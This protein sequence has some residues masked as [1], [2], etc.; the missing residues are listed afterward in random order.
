MTLNQIFSI[1]IIG[2]IY[3]YSMPKSARLWILLGVSLLGA[4]WLQPNLSIRWLDYSLPTIS[5]LIVLAFWLLGRVDSTLDRQA[6]LTLVVVAVLILFLALGR[7][8]ELPL[9]I[10]SRPPP[11]ETTT[12][13]LILSGTACL[14]L[15]RWMPTKMILAFGIS[16]LIVTLIILKAEPL[17]GVLAAWLRT[18]SGQNPSLALP[19][20]IQWLGFSYLAFRLLHIL[21]DRWNGLIHKCSL[22]EHLIYAFFLPA[23]TAGPI[24]RID[25][26]VP[27][28]RDSAAGNPQ[29]AQ[30][31]LDGLHRIGAGIVKKFLLADSLSLFALN[32]TNA[33]QAI[34]SPSLWIMLY[35]Y[36][37]RIYFDFSGY[38]D[39][40]I[41]LGMIFGIQLPENFK[42][43]YLQTTISAFWQS[44]HITL[45]TWVRTYI[46]SPLSRAMLRRKQSPLITL[47][48]GT[49]I[50]MVVIGLWH[51]VN[52][53]FISWGL[54]HAGGLIAHRIWSQRTGAWYSRIMNSERKRWLWAWMARIIT[55]HFVTL[56]WVL[57]VAP[58]IGYAI[59][60]FANLFGF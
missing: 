18:Q 40:A 45:S 20:E 56:G 34:D 24:D 48:L 36:S 25:R 31:L 52:A 30:R 58:D 17:S 21:I 37:L 53:T 12:A 16:G 19:S 55:F 2:I 43:P 54:W 27:E 59:R 6:S 50:T 13:A 60:T 11:L 57:F 29:S 28:L 35:A 39:I 49:T 38:T 51:G 44:W 14:L 3:Q 15:Q 23:Y 47:W 32:G 42:S 7:Y 46:H 22:H 10:T 26:F 41:G 33:S 1:L 4:Y 5:I 8:L 9:E